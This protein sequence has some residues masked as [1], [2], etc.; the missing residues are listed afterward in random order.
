MSILKSL[1]R[2]DTDRN[3][4]YFINLQNKLDFRIPTSFSDLLV[5]YN[6]PTP[7]LTFFRKDT[8]SFNIEYFFGFSIDENEDFFSNYRAYLNRIPQELFPIASVDGGDLLCMNKENEA[9]YYWFHEKDDWGLE[10]NEERPV[11]VA[12]S[13]KELLEILIKPEGPTQSEI[14]A[15]KKQAKITKTTPTALKFKNEA[16][17]KKGLP[18]L[19]MDDF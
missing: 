7:E 17:A 8:I 5:K 16:R 13:L 18:P 3:R 9:I 15:V 19:T 11:K 4:K 12:D 1:Y 2:V 14:D 6:I 10:G